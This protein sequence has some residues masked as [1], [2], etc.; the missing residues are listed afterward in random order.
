MS[1]AVVS[2]GTAVAKAAGLLSA[3]L[4]ELHAAGVTGGAQ[5]VAAQSSGARNGLALDDLAEAYTALPREQQA[6]RAA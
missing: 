1:A 3:A 5:A 6:A 2:Y 4:A